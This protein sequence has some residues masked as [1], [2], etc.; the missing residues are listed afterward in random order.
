MD[1]YIKQKGRLN[2]VITTAE[3]NYSPAS[4]SRSLFTATGSKEKM[5]V[6]NKKGHHNTLASC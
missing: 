1:D 2:I 6:N 5:H 4:S 3:I